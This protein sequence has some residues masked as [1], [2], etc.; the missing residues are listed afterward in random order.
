MFQVVNQILSSEVE[1]AA[2]VD[3]VT[4]AGSSNNFHVELVVESQPPNNDGAS[5]SSS[6][7]NEEQPE[8][9]KLLAAML[10]LT[11]AISNKNVIDRRR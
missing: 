3:V 4:L 11:V 7:E 1:K 8:D 2:D 5:Q 10:S 9:R 6:R